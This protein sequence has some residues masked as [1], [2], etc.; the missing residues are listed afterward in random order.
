MTTQ[1][2]IDFTAPPLTTHRAL[3]PENRRDQLGE[4]FRRFHEQN[5]TVWVLFQRFALEAIAT[6]LD[7]Y[8][9]DAINQRI[10][11]H[12]EIETRGTES[13]KMNNSFTAYYARL[14][15]LAHPSHDGF[16][17]NRRLRSGDSTAHTD[18]RHEFIDEPADAETQIAARLRSILART[19]EQRP[20]P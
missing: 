8:G 9:A 17:R 12:M 11:W 15:H 6:G 3:R 5:P 13:L 1:T 18:D 10:R 20:T 14:F 7:H 16:F 19:T 2:E 4:A